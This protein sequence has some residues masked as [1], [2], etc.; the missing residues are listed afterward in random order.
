MQI[1]IENNFQISFEGNIASGKTSILESF[2]KENFGLN[3]ITEPIEKW[4]DL[5]GHNLLELAYLKPKRWSYAFSS[6]VNLTLFEKHLDL[7][8][9]SA[10]INLMERSIYS[11]RFIFANHLLNE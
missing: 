4:C 11:S 8:T 5:N 10:K 2:K 9:S 1:N 3:I 7:S 6:Y